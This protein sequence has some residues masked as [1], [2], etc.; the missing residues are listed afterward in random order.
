MLA[1]SCNALPE[2]F[3]LLYWYS[4]T[5]NYVLPLAGTVLFA[6]AALRALRL[7]PGAQRGGRWAGGAGLGLLVG[8]GGGEITLLSC[9]VVLARLGCLLWFR[10]PG[11][12]APGAAGA[13]A[14]GATAVSADPLLVAAQ[15]TQTSPPAAARRLWAGWVLAGLLTAALMLGAPGNFRRAA[16]TD[17]GPKTRNL[18]LLARRAWPELLLTVPA[19][20]RQMQAR[21]ARLVAAAVRRVLEVVLP[22]LR[23]LTAQGLLAPIPGARQRADMNVELSED[24][25]RKNNRFLAHYFRVPRVLLSGALHQA[26]SN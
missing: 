4:G 20:A 15:P 5:V 12:P 16:L 18:C 14:T 26:M 1:L 7:A 2:P 24:S 8:I 11:G 19:H 22:P 23:W 10:G 9:L 3:T 13:A 21:Y 17:A 6:A 25:A